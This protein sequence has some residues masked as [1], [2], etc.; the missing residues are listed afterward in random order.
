MSRCEQAQQQQ[1]KHGPEGGGGP[2]APPTT[3]QVAATSPPKKT[4]VHHLLAGGA[5]GFVES[6]VCHPLDTI[7]TR[8]Q[9]RQ[10]GGSKYGML[11]TGWRIVHNE[12][13]FALYKGLTA[14]YMG[15]VPKM[16]VRFSSFES[17]KEMLAGPDGKGSQAATFMA[18]LGSGVTEALL[19]VTPAEVCKIRLQA[20]FHSMADPVQLA[21]RKYKNVLQTAYVIVKEEGIS[22]LYKGVVPTVLRQGINQAANFTCYQYCKNTITQQREK[23]ELEPWEAMLFGGLSGGVGPLL[24]NPLDVVKT[25]LQ[26]Q[27]T[28]EGHTPKYTGVLQAIPVIVREEG[29]AAL[30]KGITPRLMRIMPGQAITFMTYEFVSKHIG[31]I[32]ATIGAVLPRENDDKV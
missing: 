10:A 9:L 11:M 14:V 27:R 32:G 30:W 28:L 25:R 22:A 31:Q 4:M 24:N 26:K 7:K 1:Q 12:S 16:A 8:M 18:G 15:I 17:Y 13:F 2:A 20:Q 21:N 5:A 23:K 29:P 19:V 6:S 3:R